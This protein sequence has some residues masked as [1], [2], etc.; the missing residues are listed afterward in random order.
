MSSRA[1]EI[2]PGTGPVGGGASS[3]VATGQ[4]LFSVPVMALSLPEQMYTRPVDDGDGGADDDD[5][6]DA[7]HKHV[8]GES[9]KYKKLM[10][11]TME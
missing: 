5:A 6:A 11:S 8:E 4:Q 7:M 1:N 3:A 2:V 10:K 9:S